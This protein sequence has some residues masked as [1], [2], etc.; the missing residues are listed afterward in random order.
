MGMA[1]PKPVGLSPWSPDDC[2]AHVSN[3]THL[4]RV[5]SV[6]NICACILRCMCVLVHMCVCSRYMCAYLFKPEDNLR[7]PP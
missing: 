5:V 7:C 4:R 2:H 1:S 6:L 3:S